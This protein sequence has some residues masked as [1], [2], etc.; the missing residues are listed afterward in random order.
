MFVNIVLE[1]LLITIRDRNVIFSEDNASFVDY[2]YFLLLDD[3]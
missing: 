1:L 3:K 2:F